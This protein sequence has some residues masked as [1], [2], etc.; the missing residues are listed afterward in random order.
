MLS[1]AELWI[2]QSDN[3]L[4]SLHNEKLRMEKKKKITARHWSKFI[5]SGHQSTTSPQN[6]SKYIIMLAAAYVMTEIS[7]AL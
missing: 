4:G 6:H 7:F 2:I 5:K 1:S 3:G